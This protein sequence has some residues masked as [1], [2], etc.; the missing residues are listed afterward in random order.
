MICWRIDLIPLQGYNLLAN[1]R[2][3]RNLM[4]CTVVVPTYNEVDNLPALI[5]A[6][7]CLPIEDLSIVVVDD[8]S[9]DGTGEV[10]EGLRQRHPDILH[11]LRRPAKMGLGSAYLS[12]F[13]TALALG[14][15]AIV[16]MDAD[17]S[18]SPQDVPL[19]LAALYEYDA[20]IGSR[21]VSGGRL[22]ERWSWWRHLLSWWANAVYTRT[23]LRLQVRDATAGFKAWRR[24]A[25]QAVLQHHVRSSGYVFQVEMAYV[26][27]RLGLRSLELPIFFEDRRIGQSKMSVPIKLEAAWRVWQIR[28]HHR[29]IK[30]QITVGQAETSADRS[31]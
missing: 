10:A 16:Q 20:V 17:G 18:H 21:Y 5:G 8:A 25:L 6:L 26:A 13:Q 31:A 15:K 3:D 1:G 11:L 4:S 29:H 19:L 28:W 7:L 2:A 24:L 12:G 23:I 30:Q 27:E 9:P 14:S 22:D